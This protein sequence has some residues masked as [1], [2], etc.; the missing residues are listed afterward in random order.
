MNYISVAGSGNLSPLVLST[1]RGALL[2]LKARKNKE[3]Y[4][5]PLKQ[6]LVAAGAG[7]MEPKYLVVSAVPLA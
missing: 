7:G 3:F 2:L 1:P 4:A 5:A 6:G